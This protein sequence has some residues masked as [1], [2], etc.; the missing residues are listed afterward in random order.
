MDNLLSIETRYREH[1][2]RI[3]TVDREGWKRPQSGS[4]PYRLMGMR[5]ALAK[6]LT[7]LAI[8]L[9]PITQESQSA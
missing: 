7:S 2:E 4:H 5:S 6:C 9:A 1:S 3:A 8:R